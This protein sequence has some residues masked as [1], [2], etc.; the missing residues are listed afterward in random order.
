M[1]FSGL[2]ARAGSLGLELICW[3]AADPQSAGVPRTAEANRF[4][5]IDRTPLL[6]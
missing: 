3:R 6:P 1:G 2:S 5:D 4:C